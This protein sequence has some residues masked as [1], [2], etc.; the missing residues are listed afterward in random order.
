[1]VRAFD[2]KQYCSTSRT[3]RRL[4]CRVNWGMVSVLEAKLQLPFLAGFSRT[5]GGSFS[6]V[7]VNISHE[8]KGKFVQTYITIVYKIKR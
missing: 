8:K 1:M 4:T 6:I 2:L 3:V 7:H 5:R